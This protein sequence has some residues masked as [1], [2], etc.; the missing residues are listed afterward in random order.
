MQQPQGYV[1]ASKP[2]YVCKLLKSL[3]G[4]KQAPRHGLKGSLPNCFILVLWLLWQ[5]LLCLFISL[6]L[7]FSTY[8]CMLMILSSLV[9]LQ[10]R[11]HISSHLSVPL[12]ISRI[13]APSIIFWA[14]K[15]PPPSLVLPYPRQS[16]PLM[17]IT[18][19]ICITPSLLKLLVVLPQD[20]LQILVCPCLILLLI[21]AWL[22]HCNTSPLLDQIWPLVSISYVNLCNSLPLLIWRLL[23]G[24][25]DM[26]GALFLMEFISLEVPLL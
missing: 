12:L 2:H 6:T 9:M 20:L 23:R 16:M 5:I 25:S 1:H 21:E 26:S 15:S 8:C 18:V 11:L 4:L 19:S 3:Y 24:F 17:F 14:F 22:E 13:L 10:T 7:L